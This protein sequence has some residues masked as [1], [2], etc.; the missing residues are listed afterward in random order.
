MICLLA[1]YGSLD[2]FVWCERSYHGLWGHA[3]R[4][5]TL[6]TVTGVLSLYSLCVLDWVSCPSASLLHHTM[7][8]GGLRRC[9]LGAGQKGLGRGMLVAGQEGLLLWLVN[10]YPCHVRLVPGHWH[11]SLHLL[12]VLGL[13]NLTSDRLLVDRTT[14]SSAT[15]K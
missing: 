14:T 12:G 3:W 6:Q 13:L 2:V 8:L 9:V 4:E 5:V 1:I 10:W 15:Y 7:C 11:G